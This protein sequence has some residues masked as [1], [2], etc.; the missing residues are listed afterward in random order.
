MIIHILDK[1]WLK[2]SLHIFEQIYIHTF[3]RL[4]RSVPT[5]NIVDVG[6]DIV[7]F[8]TVAEPWRR[9]LVCFLLLGWITAGTFDAGTRIMY[10]FC[11][12]GKVITTKKAEKEERNKT[13]V[14]WH[15]MFPDSCFTG[16]LKYNVIF[17]EKRYILR[18]LCYVKEIVTSS[19]KMFILC[20]MLMD[21]IHPDKILAKIL[22]YLILFLLLFDTRYFTLLLCCFYRLTVPLRFLSHCFLIAIIVGK[23]IRSEIWR[24]QTHEKY[25]HEQLREILN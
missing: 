8:V 15:F 7:Y 6:E 13:V 16:L 21:K 10:H 12:N 23:K 20:P 1:I 17:A 11:E 4:Q 22:Y 3:T 19:C 14:L 2:Q 9:L 5:R 18:L 24:L 25:V